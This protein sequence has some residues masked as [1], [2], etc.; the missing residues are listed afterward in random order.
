MSDELWSVELGR[1]MGVI[2]LGATREEI[3]RRLAEKNIKLNVD[4]EDDWL[5]IEELDAELRFK[6]TKPAVLREI[7]VEDEQLRFA[8]L[9]VIGKRLHEVVV[10][11]KVSDA[12]TMWRLERDDE[13]RSGAIFPEGPTSDELLLSRGTLWIPSLGLGLGIVR[14]EITTVRLRKPEESPKSGLGPLTPSQRELSGRTDLSRFLLR[15]SGRVSRQI[16]AVQVVL[17]FVLAVSLGL[18][19]WQAID[20]QRR[21]NDAPVVEGTVIAVRP[22]GDPIPNEFTIAYRD[23]AGAEH[24]VVFH[25]ADVYIL[26][27]V[28]E[29]V[30]VRYL[31]EAPDQPLGPA[32]V[33]DAGFLKYMPRGIG[34]VAVYLLLQIAV[35]AIGWLLARGKAAGVAPP[36]AEPNLNH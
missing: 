6:T 25:S 35:G 31:P 18:L 27:E 29:K 24:Q 16:N 33:R 12:E 11:L 3:A 15:P 14:G 5:W 10:L 13:S 19:V 22:P 36:A 4:D 30:E 32:R 17:G 26:R 9:A 7:V 28:G 8:S 1:G 34:I 23:Q 2:E 21:W 20:Y